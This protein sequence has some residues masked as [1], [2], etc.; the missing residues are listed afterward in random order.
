MSYTTLAGP[1]ASTRAASR[2]GVIG[3]Y[4]VDLAILWAGYFIA[5]YWR[6]T[7]P[8]GRFVGEHY[9]WYDPAAYGMLAAALAVAGLLLVLPGEERL[10]S[11]ARRFWT[12]V[13]GAALALGGLTLLVPQQSG[14]QKGYFAAIDLLLVLLIRPLPR[15]AAD[16]DEGQPFGV[17][18]ARLWANRS[19]LR[20][21]VQYNVQSR[22]AQAILGILW[23]ILL[24]LSTAI[25]MSVVFS[26]IM[27]V[28]VG[29]VPFI[30][31][32]LAGLVPWGLFNQAISSGM[33]SILGAMG[34]INQIYFPREIIVLSALGEALVDTTFMFVAMLA[35]D[36]IVG[37]WP[38]PLYLALP[39]L[40]AIEVAFS[41]G[42]M[43]LVSWLSVL[44]RD[45]PQLV[46][47]LLQLVFYLCP[48]IYPA[49]IV[50]ER[51]RFLFA[52]N[53][54][55]VLIDAFRAVLVYDRAPVWSSLVYPAALAAGLLA[56]GY[57]LF[58]ANEDIFADLA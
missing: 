32:F 20:I 5:T 33:R 10:A 47:V 22:Y 39:L 9:R 29:D 56:C 51:Y 48:I 6:R 53:P 26:Q 58:K 11:A 49:S 23:I 16:V 37:I 7:L 52:L 15:R 34:L 28:S 14:W 41:L 13:F 40:L 19:L 3:D 18:L 42:L 57:R 35:I 17:Y 4:A 1:R 43:L 50:P 24:P 44:V 36:A 54:L 55:A 45:V 38:N 27:R 12:P 2:L 30:A 46:S 21:W 31:F 8:F 25:I